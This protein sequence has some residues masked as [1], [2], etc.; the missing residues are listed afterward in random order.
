MSRYEM[1]TFKK[2]IEIMFGAFVKN[3]TDL[4]LKDHVYAQ[5]QDI[6]ML[7][8][9]IIAQHLKKNSIERSF[10]MLFIVFKLKLH[11]II[12]LDALKSRPSS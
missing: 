3:Q 4:T 6:L 11:I 8:Q 5:H 10:E 7:L 2:Q 1:I 12:N 9:M